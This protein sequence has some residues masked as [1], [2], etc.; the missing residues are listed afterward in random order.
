MSCISLNVIACAAEEKLARKPVSRKLHLVAITPFLA[1]AND[2]FLGIVIPSQHEVT[3]KRVSVS[4]RHKP[5][6]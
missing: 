6:Q 4:S 3:R 2:G 1:P 5:R